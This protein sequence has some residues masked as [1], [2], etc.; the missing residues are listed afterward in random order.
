MT[1]DT[2][3]WQEYYSCAEITPKAY[4][5]PLGVLNNLCYRKIA[6]SC[7]CTFSTAELRQMA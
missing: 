1:L 7:L 5:E 2:N 3:I 6:S 4:Y